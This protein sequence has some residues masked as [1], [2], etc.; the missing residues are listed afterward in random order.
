M[1]QGIT[2]HA[3]LVVIHVCFITLNKL[4]FKPALSGVV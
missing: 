3:R 2:G 4:T 1:L